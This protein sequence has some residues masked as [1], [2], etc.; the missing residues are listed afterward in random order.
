MSSAKKTRSR[1]GKIHRYPLRVRELVIFNK[2]RYERIKGILK[3]KYAGIVRKR[4]NKNLS[5]KN[6]KF[7]IVADRY[8]S[9]YYEPS[10]IIYARESSIWRWRRV[11]E[12]F[13]EL[14]NKYDIKTLVK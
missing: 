6:K 8:I 13:N 7:P 9:T 10:N 3:R 5:A 14:K 11:N 12:W 1:N 4:K 2:E